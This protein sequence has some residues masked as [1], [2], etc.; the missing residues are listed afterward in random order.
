MGLSQPALSHALTRLRYMLKDDLFI[1]TPAGMTPTPRAEQLGI[2]LKEALR[3]VQDAVQPEAFD[4]ATAH[5]H[6]R[7]AVDTYAA[8]V[9]VRRLTEWVRARAECAARFPL[10]LADGCDRGA[11]RQ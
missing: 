1:S 3:K 4:P 8:V 7:I 9:F 11:G 5:H 10:E 2:P 6:F